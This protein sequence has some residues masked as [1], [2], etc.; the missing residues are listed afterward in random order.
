M[1]QQRIPRHGQFHVDDIPPL[2]SGILETKRWTTLIDAGCGDGSLLHALNQIITRPGAN[3]DL[4]SEVDPVM[5]RISWAILKSVRYKFGYLI[6]MH[7][8]CLPYIVVRKP[9]LEVNLGVLY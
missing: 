8:K 4:G 5:A 7:Q 3:C 2:L 6:D 9:T 1:I